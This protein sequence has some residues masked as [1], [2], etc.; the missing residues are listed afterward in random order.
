MIDCGELPY[1]TTGRWNSGRFDGSNR[2]AYEQ[3]VDWLAS[4]GKGRR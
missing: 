4:E 3:I 1:A 2:E